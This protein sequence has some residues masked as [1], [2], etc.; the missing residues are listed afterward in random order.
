MRWHLWGPI[1]PGAWGAVRHQRYTFGDCELDVPARVEVRNAT[2]TVVA[3]ASTTPDTTE[4]ASGGFTLEAAAVRLSLP[5][6]VLSIRVTAPGY[7]PAELTWAPRVGSLE[8]D[9]IAV[10]LARH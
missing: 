7:A 3:E 10:M 8:G 5:R 2:G 4:D 1:A 9:M 6:E